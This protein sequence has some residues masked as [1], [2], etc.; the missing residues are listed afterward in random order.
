V[1][2]SMTETRYIMND[3]AF[4]IT[5]FM[6]QKSWHRNIQKLHTYLKRMHYNIVHKMNMSSVFFIK[7]MQMM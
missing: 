3:S 7:V 4:K 6:Q 1:T 5:Q 2:S